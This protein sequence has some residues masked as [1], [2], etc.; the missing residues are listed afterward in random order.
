MP[1]NFSGSLGSQGHSEI[2]VSYTRQKA[3]S[4]FFCLTNL[5]FTTN[6]VPEESLSGVKAQDNGMLLCAKADLPCA[7]P[8]EDGKCEEPGMWGARQKDPA[9]WQTNRH[10]IDLFQKK[11]GRDGAST[12]SRSFAIKLSKSEQE[13]LEEEYER[14]LG[15]LIEGMRL[16]LLWQSKQLPDE[17][18]ASTDSDPPSVNYL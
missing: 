2:L 11:G 13:E 4:H 8:S 17:D 16:R 12:K 1:V 6:K 18:T 15:T 9:L 14:V 5:S 10:D 3:G 7:Y